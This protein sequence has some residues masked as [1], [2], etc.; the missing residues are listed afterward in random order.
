MGSIAGTLLV[1]ESAT[2]TATY[3]ITQADIDATFV[4]NQAMV[5]GTSPASVVVDD[6]SDSSNPADANETGTPSDPNGDDPTNTPIPAPAISL[7]KGS[8]L[9]LGADNLATVGDIITYTYTATNT[10]K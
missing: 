3:A 4:N 5:E 6:L 10:G 8:S 2:Y 7:V 9:D 1:G